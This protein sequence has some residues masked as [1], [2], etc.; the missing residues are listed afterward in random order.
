MP[1]G[2]FWSAERHEKC[3]ALWRQGYSGSQVAKEC[4]VTRNS[5]LGRLHRTGQSKRDSK[6]PV[7]RLRRY[8]RTPYLRLQKLTQLMLADIPA[9]A[10]LNAEHNV[11]F[12]FIKPN[13]CREILDKRGD[14]GLPMCCGAP[15]KPTHSWCP[16]HHK[17]N[18]T[19]RA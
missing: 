8:A 4:G 10:Q 1:S 12:L 11:G 2:S 5:V 16:Y 18:Y 17:I 3:V 13:Q 9:P 6:M 14:D 19:P 15:V 7:V